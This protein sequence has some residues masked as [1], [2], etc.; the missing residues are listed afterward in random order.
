MF[1]HELVCLWNKETEMT[2][3]AVVQTLAGEPRHVTVY[4][5]LCPGYEETL[6]IELLRQHL[7]ADL[8]DQNQYYMDIIAD[9]AKRMGTLIDDLLTF[10]RTGRHE[11]SSRPVNLS[12]LAR[13][14]IREL[15]SDTAGRDIRWR[16]ADLPVV[17]GDRAMLRVVLVNLL[18]NAVKFTRT[19]TSAEIEIGCQ[20][21]AGSEVVIYVRDNGVGFDMQYADKL[22][23]V[24]QRLHHADKKE[25]HN[26]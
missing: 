15:E 23:G 8:D 3:N 19:R 26:R 10:S 20:P 2:R 11:L 5:S 21:G 14:V 24:F 18:A 6:S 17:T 16:I 9:A 1:R 4:F 7:A 13:E 25:E 22:F 12:A